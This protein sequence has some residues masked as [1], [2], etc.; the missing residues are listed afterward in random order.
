LTPSSA[1]RVVGHDVRDERLDDV[2]AELAHRLIQAV[3]HVDGDLRLL[4]EGLIQAW[5]VSMVKADAST[6]S[7]AT[8]TSGA[9]NHNVGISVPATMGL[10][11]FSMF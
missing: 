8:T 1:A 7:S 5:A 11:R 6:T 3:L 9:T 2:V 4:L 10:P